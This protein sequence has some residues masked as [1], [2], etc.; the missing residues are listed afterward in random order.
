MKIYFSFS[1]KGNNWGDI[2]TSGW[3]LRKKDASNGNWGGN[4][5]NPPGQWGDDPNK[6]SRAPGSGFASSGG[7]GGPRMIRG[8]GESQGF[9]SD[10]NM[11]G[12]NNDVFPSGSSDPS[13]NQN[14]GHPIGGQPGSSSGSFLK[15]HPRSC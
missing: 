2:D 6:G 10:N 8:G 15:F 11:S 4:N 12:S 1:K 14:S 3:G 5:S 7:N 13:N 9:G